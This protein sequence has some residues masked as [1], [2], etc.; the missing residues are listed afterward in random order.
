MPWGGG[1][2]GRAERDRMERELEAWS[3][4]FGGYVDAALELARRARERPDRSRD[5][6]I[7]AFDD[8]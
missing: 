3:A 6:W 1:P 5:L 2:A 8:E 7:A 4:A